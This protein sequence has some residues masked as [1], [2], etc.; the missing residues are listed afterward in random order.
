MKNMK[1]N[2]LTKVKNGE[3]SL[4][5]FLG[6]TD[7]TV[8]EIAALAGFDYMRLDS[9][10]ALVDPSKLAATIRIANAYDIPTL[11]RVSCFEEM[12]KLLDYGATGFLV[13]DVDSKEAAQ[14]A[15][16]CCKYAPVGMRGLSRS[17]RCCQYGNIPTNDYLE[18][19]RDNITLAVQIESKEAVERL[20]EILSVEGVDIVAVGRLDL[21]QSYGV[22]GQSNHPDVVAAENLVIQKALEY[23]KY[24]LITASS[25]KQFEELRE[26]GVK[27]MTIAFDTQFILKAFKDHIQKFKELM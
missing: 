27:L 24:P 1:N 23:G 6:E 18:F 22:I 9:E 12:T 7:I 16:N 20:D 25:P 3:C 26:K 21:S 19:A 5:V 13:P 8:A 2:M 14:A 10:H 17:N 11:V 4:G 15:V